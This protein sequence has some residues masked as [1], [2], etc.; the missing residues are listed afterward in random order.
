MIKI[1]KNENCQGWIQVFSFGQFVDEVQGRAKAMRIASK[2]AR[3]Q[4]QPHLCR[5]GKVVKTDL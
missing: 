5:F 1:E 4:G 2:I 3:E